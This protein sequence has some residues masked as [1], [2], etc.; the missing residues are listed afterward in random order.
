MNRVTQKNGKL[1]LTPADHFTLVLVLHNLPHG[2]QEAEKLVRWNL[3][4]PGGWNK[5]EE[6]TNAKAN[7]I[8]KL[9]LNKTKSV[10]ETIEEFENIHN[11]IKFQSFGKTRINNE[12]PKYKEMEK[13]EQEGVLSEETQAKSLIAVQNIGRGNSK[14]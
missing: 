14:Y 12:K 2:N 3:H 13:I 6:N 5:Y 9:V 1:T 4:K 7:D 10:E 8:K 11:K